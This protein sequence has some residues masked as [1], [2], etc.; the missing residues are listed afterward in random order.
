M[1]SNDRDHQ[2]DG[3]SPNGWPR[4]GFGEEPCSVAEIWRGISKEGFPNPC[5]GIRRG[6]LCRASVK[7]HNGILTL[8]EP[9]AEI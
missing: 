4:H 8:Y 3:G 7:P 1:V 9:E 5:L 2:S 6:P